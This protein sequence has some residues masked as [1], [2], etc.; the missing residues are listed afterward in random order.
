MERG[1]FFRLVSFRPCRRPRKGKRT[2][3]LQIDSKYEDGSIP[4]TSIQQ[5][6]CPGCR[7][8]SSLCDVDSER[9]EEILN[10]IPRGTVSLFL[11]DSVSTERKLVRIQVVK[12]ELCGV[13]DNQIQR[14]N[15]DPDDKREVSRSD[16][17]VLI[18]FLNR[19]G[20][21]EEPHDEDD[22]EVCAR[23]FVRTI[24]ISRPIQSTSIQSSCRTIK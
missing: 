24:A 11:V 10:R 15:G 4:V 18:D 8:E 16:E 3:M 17:K 14:L 12:P 22:N 2:M 1:R 5:L 7:L 19:Q 6:L 21:D 13:D 9:I 23:Y 20:F